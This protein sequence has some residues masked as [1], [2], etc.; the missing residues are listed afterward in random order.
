MKREKTPPA[1][2]YMIR[3]ARLGHQINFSYCRSENMGVPCF[4]TLDCW[5]EHFPVQE[6]L[7]IE[8]TP[9][10]WEM[11]FDRPPKPK[12]LSLVEMIEQA[13]RRKKGEI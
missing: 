11:I 7:R 2:D 9:E 3:C 1:E 6:Y 13:K 5:Y 8:L 12:I 10:E 4:K